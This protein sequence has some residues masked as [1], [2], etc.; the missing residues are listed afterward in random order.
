VTGL[1]LGYACVNTQLP[2]AGRTA[3][4]ANLTTE[5]I[6]ELVQAN[7]SALEAILRWNRGQ[8]IQ[9][10]RLTSNVIPFASHPANTLRWWEVFG[11]RLSRLGGLIRSGGMRISTHPGQYIVLSS[12]RAEVVA[13]AVAELDYHDRLLHALGLGSSH[14]IV[15]HPGAGVADRKA[16]YDRFAAGYAR[17]SAGAAARL[18]LENDERWPLDTTLALAE[19]LGIPVVFDVFHHRLAPSLGPR[20]TRELVL[21][22]G[23]TWRRRDGRQEVHFSTQE[24]GKRPGAHAETIDLDAFDRFVDEVGDLPLDCILEVKDKE[25]SVLRARARLEAR[26]ARS[27]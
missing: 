27:G 22:A 12:T 2:S 19:R 26:A 25:Q 20:G 21:R 3:R 9:V 1:R 16:A 13:A 17:L 11:E 7:L 23:E 18:V 5:R 15:L 10:F 4:L 8:G 14:R 24:P 6:L